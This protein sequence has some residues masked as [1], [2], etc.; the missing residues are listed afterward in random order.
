MKRSDEQR[1]VLNSNDSFSALCQLYSRPEKLK[2]KKQLLVFKKKKNLKNTNRKK[3]ESYI[4]FKST[5]KK[6]KIICSLPLKGNLKHLKKKKSYF[7]ASYFLTTWI[8]N[9]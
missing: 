6:K 9:S 5:M 8:Q 1:G 7:S 2:S 3:N 4:Q